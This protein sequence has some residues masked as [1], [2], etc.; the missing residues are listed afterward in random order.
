MDLDRLELLGVTVEMVVATIQQ[1]DR[2]DAL[3]AW[4]NSG[5]RD[6]ARRTH[7]DVGGDVEVFLEASG[8]RDWIRTATLMD[9]AALVG[10]GEF[11]DESSVPLR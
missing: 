10:L 8:T 9:L 7:P 4:A 11:L 2:L 6:I 5:Y 3:R 1:P